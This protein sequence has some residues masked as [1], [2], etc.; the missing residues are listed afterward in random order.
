MSNQRLRVQVARRA[1]QL[2]YDREVS[3]YFT[4]KRRAAREMGLDERS[5]DLPS[6]REIR[7]HVQILADLYEGERRLE[8]LR[9]M[10][11]DALVL[12]RKLGAFHPNLIGSTLTGHVRQGSDID[13][14]VFADEV[15]SL[16]SLLE[17][18]G[19]EFA[20]E[21]KRIIKH[22]EARLFTHIHIKQRFPIEITVYATDKIN[23]PFKSS[24][25]GKTIEKANRKQLEAL[26]RSEYP[27]LDIDAALE[28]VDDF[29]D[30][31]PLLRLLLLPLEEVKQSRQHHPEG[32][33]L[34]HS[35]QVFELARQER[36]W[37]QE[38]LMAALLHDVG[39]A[40]D[41][42]DH[43][44]AALEALEGMI[45]P[46]TEFLIGHHMQAHAYRDGTLG[47]RAKRR[48]RETDDLED[49]L[50]L[51]QLDRGGRVP[52]RPVPSV[53]DALEYLR[54]LEEM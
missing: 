33:A 38:F 41:P 44:A 39:K 20:V 1:A 19:Y 46:R 42:G 25:T 5:G 7:E 9:Q 15:S 23:Y 47:E 52:G 51:Q 26:L 22:G 16:T 50:L 13:I 14:H 32:D 35:L 36:P 18:E 34:Y 10:R 28:E 54:G 17:D 49:L 6:N 37:D 11:L 53:G 40:I 29:A 31:F 2:M 24:I 27:D 45:T 8:N 43:V 12:M 21:R 48:L 30:V 3:E 4:A